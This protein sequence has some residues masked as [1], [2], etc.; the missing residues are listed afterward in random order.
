[1]GSV[2]VALDPS[3]GVRRRHLPGEAGEEFETCCVPDTGM[4]LATSI[5]ERESGSPA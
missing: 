3:V 5:V 4:S 1:M 2:T